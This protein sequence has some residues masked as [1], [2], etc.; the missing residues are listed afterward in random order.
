MQAIFLVVATTA[1]VAPVAL[2][3]ADDSQTQGKQVPWL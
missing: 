1:V 3:K 2:A